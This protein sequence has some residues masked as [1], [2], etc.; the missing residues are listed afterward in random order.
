MDSNIVEGGGGHTVGLTKKGKVFS[1][2]ENNCGQL[3]HGDQEDRSVPT[4]IAGLDGLVIIQI[5]CGDFHMA[6]LT[7]KVELLTWYVLS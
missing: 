5:S 4:T 6:A 7:D 1:W 3:G 2:G